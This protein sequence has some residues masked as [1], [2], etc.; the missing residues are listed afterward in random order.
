MLRTNICTLLVA[1]TLCFAGSAAAKAPTSLSRSGGWEIS[2]GGTCDLIGR[3]GQGVD[4][5]R[6]VFTKHGPWDVI[7]LTFAPSNFPVLSSSTQVTVDFGPI[8]NPKKIEWTVTAMGD[9]KPALQLSGQRLDD[10]QFKRNETPPKIS[11]KQISNI[12]RL[13]ITVGDAVFQLN[14]GSMGRPIEALD[15]CINRLIQSWGY[16]PIEQA[17]LSKSPQ[18]ANYP[19]NWVTTN[20]Y[21]SEAL[22]ARMTGTVWFRL[23]LDTQ[24]RVAACHIQSSTAAPILQAATCDLVKSRARFTP[25]QDAGGKFVHAYYLNKVRWNPPG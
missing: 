20:D 7:D 13:V 5:T 25:A 6:L 18:P 15:Q 17:S 16:D 1:F 4:T 12:D 22:R 8:E 23:D 2:E 21:P 3:F 14:L 10:Y 19:G 9:R 11:P 24:G